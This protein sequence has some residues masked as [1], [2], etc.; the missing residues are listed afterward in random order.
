MRG[1]SGGSLEVTDRD[2]DD[3]DEASTEAA[4]FG[5]FPVEFNVLRDDEFQVRRGYYGLAVTY[6]DQQEVIPI[7][8]RVDD[9][10]FRLASAISNMTTEERQGGRLPS[11]VRGQERFLDSRSHR[12]PGRSIQPELGRPGQRHDGH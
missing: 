7:I 12:D 1:A 4:A 11:G 9:L 2:P 10:E 8:D 3:D 6:A 5:V